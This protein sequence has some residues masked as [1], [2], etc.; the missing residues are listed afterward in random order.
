[1]K[2]LL[3]IGA[4]LVTG[5]AGAAPFSFVDPDSKQALVHGDD[6]VVQEGATIVRTTLYRDRSQALIARESCRYKAATLALEH[7]TFEDLQLGERSEV[8]VA[9]TRAA[10][11][12]RDRH[13]AALKS[14]EIEW[15]AQ[16]F[17]P[18]LLAD[19]IALRWQDL[20]RKG[21]VDFDM[22]VP[23]MLR[24]MGFRLRLVRDA[25]AK[26]RVV[27]VEPSLFLLRPFV[28]S[29]AF[30]FAD[31]AAPRLLAYRGPASVPIAG[32]RHKQIEVMF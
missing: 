17:S 1:M 25:D 3:L 22:F 19:L 20:T 18:K 8:S 11:S 31:E 13:D 32:E 29:I 27:T 6:S 24:T 10:V 4:S 16:S 23:F 9:G 7:Y 26:T 30:T 2:C 5:R 14:D 15:D 28:P 12:Y 21:S